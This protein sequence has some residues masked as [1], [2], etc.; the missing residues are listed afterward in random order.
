MC[1]KPV[2]ESLEGEGQAFEPKKITPGNEFRIGWSLHVQIYS[3]FP[4]W[5][6]ELSNPRGVCRVWI[7]LVWQSPLNNDLTQMSNLHKELNFYFS[8]WVR[9]SKRRSC[10]SCLRKQS[11]GC[12][13]AAGLCLLC[14]AAATVGSSP[15]GYTDTR[16]RQRSSSFHFSAVQ[17]EKHHLK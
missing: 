1:L 15:R 13:G 3:F 11:A 14:S 16:A 12:A 2:R 6:E 9:G 17:P 7:A 10:V 8:R 4:P 5:I